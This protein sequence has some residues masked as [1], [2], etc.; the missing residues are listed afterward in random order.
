MTRE[1]IEKKLAGLPVCEYAF[2]RTEDLPFREEVRYICQTECPQYGK[3]WS[4][5]PAVGSVEK[6]KER[7]MHF[8]EGILFTTA[9]EDVDTENMSAMLA[10]RLAHG[11]V[12]RQLRDA[13]KEEGGEVLALSAE[14]CAL[15][16]Q[17]S[18]PDAPCRFPDRML[19]CIES[20]GILV[21]ELAEKY[22]LTFFAGGGLVIWFGLILY[23]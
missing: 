14:S 19:P 22:G 7:C 5:P 21:T 11:K 3:S 4:C 9:A 18:W 23:S 12:T 16:E 20:Y 6:C 15:C 17:C 8:R 2:V 1:E 10:T 13:L